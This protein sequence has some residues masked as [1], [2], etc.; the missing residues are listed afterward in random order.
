MPYSTIGYSIDNDGIATVTLDRPDELNALTLQMAGELVA[1]MDEI[2]G[3]DEVCAAVFTGR[4]RAFCA[5]ADLSGGTRIFE[6]AAADGFQMSRD[7][8][9]GGTIS[10]RLFESTKPLIAAINGPAVGVGITATLPMDV[11]LASDTARIGF[12]FGRRGLVPEA[13]S[14]WFLPRLVGISQA[15]EW[16]YTGRLFGAAEAQRAGLVRS[17]HPPAELLPA[18]YALAREMTAHSSAVSIAISRRMLWQ[19]LGAGSPELA[20]ELD[21]RG[22]FYLHTDADCQEGVAAFLAKRPASFPM[23]VPRDLP[24]YMRRWQQLGSAEALIAADS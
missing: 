24:A 23:R 5:G 14:S 9:Y 18:A 17:V 2:D 10:R 21:S 15:L 6:R 12:V 20:H 16:I 7:A 11:R 4:G 22:I 19:M 13:C 3:D 1:V 8:D